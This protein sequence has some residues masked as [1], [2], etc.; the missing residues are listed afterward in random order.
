MFLQKQYSEFKCYHTQILYH[1]I[2]FVIKYPDCPIFSC[3][4]YISKFLIDCYDT[5]RNMTLK[6]GSLL[7][8]SEKLPRC[9]KIRAF[10]PPK[11]VME[12]S[13]KH[14]DMQRRKHPQFSENMVLSWGWVMP[15]LSAEKKMILE[16]YL[17]YRRKLCEEVN[18]NFINVQ[19][20]RIWN[21]LCTF[22]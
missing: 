17:Q 10:G 6:G 4:Q 21:T 18:L 2:S 9:R 16:R 11:T 13:F 8:V 3:L 22:C 20:L 19:I 7:L 15:L 1:V 14:K 12:V 5:L